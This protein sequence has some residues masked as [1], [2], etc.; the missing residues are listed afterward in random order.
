[1]HIIVIIR[2]DPAIHEQR[3]VCSSRSTRTELDLAHVTPHLSRIKVKNSMCIQGRESTATIAIVESMSMHVRV[4]DA[5]ESQSL[6][7]K[8]LLHGSRTCADTTGRN[9]WDAWSR[10]AWV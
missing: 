7:S 2:H 3:I 6:E 4:R 5:S 10:F 9:T 8:Q 1:M